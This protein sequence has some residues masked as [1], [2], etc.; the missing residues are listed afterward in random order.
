MNDPYKYFRIEARE[1]LDGLNDAAH[2]LERGANGLEV[3]PG[4]LRQAHT[5]K[6]AARVVRRAGIADAAHA[7]EELLEPFREAVQAIPPQRLGSVAELLDGIGHQ[8]AE[9][10]APATGEGAGAPASGDSTPPEA[11]A[12]RDVPPDVVTTVRADVEEVDQVLR[13]LGQAHA[14]LGA[15]RGTLALANEA[16]QMTQAA[17]PGVTELRRLVDSLERGIRD[18]TDRVDRELRQVRDSVERLRVVPAASIFADLDR[19]AQD[20][21]RTQGKQ[22][23]FEG[24]GGQLRLDA[25]IIAAAQAALHQIVRNAVA[26]GIE[27]RQERAAAGKPPE[28]RVILQVARRDRSVIFSCA[29]DGRGIDLDAVRRAAGR[30]GVPVGRSEAGEQSRELIDLLFRGGISTAGSVTEVSGRGI[31][32]DIVRDAASRMGGE[33]TVRTVAG[34]G[35]TVELVAPLSLTLLDVLTIDAGAGPLA[36]PSTAVRQVARVMADALVS[37]PNGQCVLHDGQVLP[38]LP[39]AEVLPAGPADDED[40]RARQAWACLVVEGRDGSAA[41]GVDRLL[42]TTGVAVHPLPEMLPACPAVSG[43]WL[44]PDGTPQLL[45]DPDGLVAAAMHRPARPERSEPPRRSPILVVD[46]SLTT[47]MLEQSIL[48]SAGY[49]VEVASS[50]EQ[51]LELTAANRY[52]LALVDV[53]MPGMDGFTFVEHVR[54]SQQRELPCILV[55]SLDSS[56]SR[57][58]GA[59]CGAQAYIAKGEF[60]QGQLLARIR[61]LVVD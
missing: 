12:S 17:A 27:T 14:G 23:L 29:D 25:H 7:L 28:G 39:L 40:M 5:L 41:I 8:V 60:D 35:T 36:V 22:V 9:L 34:R 54:A 38:F 4:M 18:G 30:N 15:L 55:T 16:R 24:R 11:A 44:D 52:C 20:V 33:V 32:L 46:D 48:E 43:A 45:L 47:R 3:V 49:A 50:A 61:E 21:A 26:H 56:E 57:Q 53:E 10:T 13:S 58:R 2:R 59:A 31:G 51:A 1:L 6:G 37:G 19:A 42:G